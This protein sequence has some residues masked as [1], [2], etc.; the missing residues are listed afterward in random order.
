M[1]NMVNGVGKAVP[2]DRDR[3]VLTENTQVEQTSGRPVVR[4]L[5]QFIG[6][7]QNGQLRANTD[8]RLAACRGDEAEIQQHP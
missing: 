2:S 4:L 1:L 7:V 3:L 5:K 8:R 6:G